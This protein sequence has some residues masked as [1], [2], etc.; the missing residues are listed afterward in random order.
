MGEGGQGYGIQEQSS[1]AH[2]RGCLI[3]VRRTQARVDSGGRHGTHLH[4]RIYWTGPHLTTPLSDNASR[5]VGKE[6]VSADAD[7]DTGAATLTLPIVL[8]Y[9]MLDVGCECKSEVRV[10]SIVG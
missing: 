6:A 3:R 4:A 10:W 2:N 5:D 8:H 1:K 9:H 7:M